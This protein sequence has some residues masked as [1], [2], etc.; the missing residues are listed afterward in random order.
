MRPGLFDVVVIDDAPKCKLTDVL[1][2]IFRAKRLVVIGDPTQL[3]APEAPC[4]AEKPA[5]A[6]RYGIEEWTEFLGHAGNNAYK[7]AV[8]VLPRGEADVISLANADS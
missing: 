7:A 8:G 5:L 4:E 3:P 2:L 6:A 1:P